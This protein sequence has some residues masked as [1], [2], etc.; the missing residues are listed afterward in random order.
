M[1]CRNIVDVSARLSVGGWAVL[2][3]GSFAN[4]INDFVLL[5]YP[6]TSLFL[7][8]GCYT[9]SSTAEPLLLMLLMLLFV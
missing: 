9:A 1:V 3:T 6:I 7:F 4:K 5:I 8:R 2:P